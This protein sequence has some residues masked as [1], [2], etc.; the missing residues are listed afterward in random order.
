MLLTLGAVIGLIVVAVVVIAALN[1]RTVDP[2]DPGQLSPL[3]D[4]QHRSNVSIAVG[5]SF[6]GDHVLNDAN[7]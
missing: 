1:G 4:G 3:C 2:T 5:G 6:V 7:R